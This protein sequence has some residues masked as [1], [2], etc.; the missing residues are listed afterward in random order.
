MKKLLIYCT[1][2]GG[3]S[4]IYCNVLA[5]WALNRGYFVHLAYGG[6]YIYDGYKISNKLT[7]LAS[8]YITYYENV[9]NIKLINVLNDVNSMTLEQEYNFIRNLQKDLEID[10]TILPDGSRDLDN[11]RIF[12]KQNKLNHGHLF[13]SFTICFCLQ[14]GFYYKN[15]L[16]RYIGIRELKSTTDF[17]KIVI[18]DEFLFNNVKSRKFGFVPDISASYN[19]KS[20]TTYDKNVMERYNNFLEVNKNKEV[21]FYFGQANLR[22]G[23]DIL[24]KL[25]SMNHNLVLV[26]CGE[27]IKSIREDL[28]YSAIMSQLK[29]ENRIFLYNKFVTSDK[30]ISEFFNSINFLVLGHRNHYLSSG[31]MIQA[32]LYNKPLIV[33]NMGL[34]GRRVRENKVGL[35]YRPCSIK[36]LN[37]K[38]ILMSRNHKRY[39][40]AVKNYKNGFSRSAIFGWLDK[41]TCND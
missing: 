21:V 22:K 17:D 39:L 12:Y 7:K 31:T 23:Y 24:L 16:R 18:F 30:M 35:V 33:P 38:I 5:D 10:I 19:V 2:I 36:D 9:K 27:I 11:L 25:V 29:K 1:N 14:T 37:Q 40:D 41:D 15:F 6:A 8:P 34:M 13:N 28:N 3:H 26:H 32:L 4:Q 20:D